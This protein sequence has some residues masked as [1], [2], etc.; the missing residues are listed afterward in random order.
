MGHAVNETHVGKK[1]SNISYKKAFTWI[2]KAFLNLTE[3]YFPGSL[4]YLG[5]QDQDPQSF[6][7]IEQWKRQ[8][9]TGTAHYRVGTDA[10]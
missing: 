7:N 4:S 10:E 6:P 2:C 8:Y 3:Q 5:D 9:G 1:C